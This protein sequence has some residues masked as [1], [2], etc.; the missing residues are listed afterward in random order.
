MLDLLSAHF[1]SFLILCNCSDLHLSEK[2][3]L[4][5]LCSE[6]DTV[7]VQHLYFQLFRIGGSTTPL[8]QGG[9]YLLFTAGQ[10][11]RNRTFVGGKPVAVLASF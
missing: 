4:A 3:R 8:L 11:S 10:T 2:G 5:K 7:S 6:Q 1:M 9:L